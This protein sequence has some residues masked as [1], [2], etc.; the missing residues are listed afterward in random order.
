MSL[1]ELR[2]AQGLTQEQLAK[3]Q[4]ASAPYRCV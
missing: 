1:R 2:K 3:G 4:R